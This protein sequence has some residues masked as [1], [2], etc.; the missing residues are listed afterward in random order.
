MFV[1]QT[2]DQYVYGCPVTVQ[3]DHKPLAAI[4]NKP[5]RS[6]PERLQG[7][8]MKV[9]KYDMSIVY[10]PGPEMYLADNAQGEFELVNA[11]KLLPMTDK[12]LDE[13]TISTCDDDVLQQ[14]KQ[15][16]QTGWHKDKQEL[17]NVLAPS[18]SFSDELSVYD[19]LV[20]KG[21]RF[22]IPKQILTRTST[23]LTNGCLRSTRE[24][25]Y[26]PGVNAELKEYISQ[27]ETC[28]KYEMGQQRE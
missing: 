16:I 17:P 11:V 23:Q 2:F 10:K 20:F 6:A 4:S 13:M 14:M 8:L 18:L 21:E 9:Q 3:S 19:G 28:S 12:R 7:M 22:L 25:M 15:V 1:L 5:L 24:C 27:C 26:W